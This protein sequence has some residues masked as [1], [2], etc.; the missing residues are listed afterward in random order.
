MLRQR[1]HHERGD[2]KTGEWRLEHVGVVIGDRIEKFY[3][4]H[5]EKLSGQQLQSE[6]C[7]QHSFKVERIDGSFDIDTKA[8][9]ERAAKT[10]AN[11]A[12]PARRNLLAQIAQLR[13][14]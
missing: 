8:D 6:A 11:D 13:I 12:R 5:R 9:L 4:E 14:T 10:L 2:N 1:Q 7:E 3:V